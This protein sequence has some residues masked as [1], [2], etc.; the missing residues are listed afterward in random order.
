LRRAALVAAALAPT[1]CGPGPP[2]PEPRALFT[3]VTPESGLALV[4]TAGG[5]EPRQ[6]VEV[7]GGGLGL[8]DFDADGDLDVF[9]PNG[10]TLE[11]PTRG[12]GARLF[13][14][15]GGLRFHDATAEAELDW[16]GWGMGV[17]VGDVDAN[18]WDDVF[19]AAFGADALLVNDRGR[20]RAASADAGLG[21]GGWGTGSAFAD[22][23]QDGDLD[24]YLVR[25]LE[26]DLAAP[27]PPTT[28]LGVQVFD[29]PAG[30]VPLADRVYANDGDG[31]FA[32]VTAAWGCAEV[33]PSYG[34]GCLALDLDADGLCDVYVGN[35]SMPNFLFRGVE[36]RDGDAR[37][38]AEEALSDGVAVNADGEAQATMGIA[39]GDVN[40]D[41]LAD[42]FSTNFMTDTNTLFVSTPSQRFYA[43]RTQRYGLAMSSRPFLGWAALFAD[44]DLDGAEDLLA[45]N[46]HVYPEKAVAALGT[47]SRQEPLF[48]LRAGE[49]F[50][51]VLADEGGAWLA[52]K[53]ADRSA[54]CADLDLDGDLDFVVAERNGPLRLL[55][56]EAA[57]SAR[58]FTVRLRDARA[59]AANPRGL[60][61]RV[62]LTQG[63]ADEPR[64]VLATRWLAGG[65]SYL[66]ACAPELH[67]ALP[68]AAE[69]LALEVTWPDGERQVVALDADAAVQEI[70]RMR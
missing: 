46:G 48:Y 47:E 32:D 14:N 24:L 18:G 69:M 6:I 54:V 63:G 43:D 51:R 70:V 26:L 68:R 49:R 64:R 31:R 66:A 65:G 36:P 25:Y 28:F 5:S 67:F 20:L 37:R 15:D 9:A 56:G 50:R 2:V 19:V 38:F 17:A 16:H 7:K 44:V 11:E 41:G 29:G 40:A 61:A 30:L 10:A 22:L 59:G 60:G 62:A 39:W 4:L 55:R 23:D 45:F 8:V 1:A 13:A 34:L 57:R 52:S 42:L 33:R 21:D 53:H 3:D 12:A 35:D 27:P 58:G